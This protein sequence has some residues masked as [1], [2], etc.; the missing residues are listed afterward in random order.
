MSWPCRAVCGISE[1]FF[2]AYSASRFHWHLLLCLEISLKAALSFE[3]PLGQSLPAPICHPAH[4]SPLKL[5]LCAHQG[6]AT[7]HNPF[8]ILTLLLLGLSGPF[9]IAD[10]LATQFW[11]SLSSSGCHSRSPFPLSACRCCCS[12]YLL[13]ATSPYPHPHLTHTCRQLPQRRPRAAS[14]QTAIPTP[15]PPPT[16][17]RTSQTQHS[18]METRSALLH[19]P[20]TSPIQWEIWEVHRTPQSAC[21]VLHDQVLLVMPQTSQSRPPNNPA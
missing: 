21:L 6:P 14:L 4:A 5:P 16:D 10:C 11:G 15:P 1:P 8:L 3:L 9:E 18:K 19:A 2:P 17:T 20:A 7:S 12:S 13:R